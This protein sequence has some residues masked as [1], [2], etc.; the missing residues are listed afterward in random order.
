M[1]VI[2]NRT[3][4][5]NADCEGIW[6]FL[7]GGWRTRDH[8]RGEFSEYIHDRDHAGELRDDS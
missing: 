3:A 6:V 8:E 4:R 1:S 5:A 7:E 2:A